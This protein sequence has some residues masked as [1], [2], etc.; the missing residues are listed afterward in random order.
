MNSSAHSS[1]LNSTKSQSAK[2]LLIADLPGKGILPV[3]CFPILYGGS[4][5]MKSILLSGIRLITS[6][7][8]P[9]IT[10]LRQSK[11]FIDYS[12]GRYDDLICSSASLIKWASFLYSS[13]TISKPC[14]DLQTKFQ[15]S[16]LMHNSS[17]EKNCSTRPCL[18]GSPSP[19][20]L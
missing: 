15:K 8:S 10:H 20:R 13:I 3:E 17:S 18:H 5:R 14:C 2:S 6:L 7:L 12:L 19:Y 16:L 1:G 11:S 4:V 9:Q